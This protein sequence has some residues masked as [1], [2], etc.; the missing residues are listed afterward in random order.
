MIT[1][2]DW[3]DKP[4]RNS[5]FAVRRARTSAFSGISEPDR[6]VWQR[7][8]VRRSV[9][10]S[11]LQFSIDFTWKWTGDPIKLRTLLITFF[12]NSRR[13]GCNINTHRKRVNERQHVHAV[14]FSDKY[15]SWCIGFEH[16][17]Q[18]WTMQLYTVNTWGVL[19]RSQIKLE[20]KASFLK[21]HFF[22][23]FFCV[24]VDLFGI[25]RGRCRSWGSI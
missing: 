13:W 24:C 7:R 21:T 19:W 4:C 9:R 14:M 2:V 5:M 16:P 11:R 20:S 1:G 23:Y 18:L 15:S 25:Q 12:V 17:R 6:R 22:I 3:S 8:C 10:Y